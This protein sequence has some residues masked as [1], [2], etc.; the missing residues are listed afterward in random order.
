MTIIM[1]PVKASARIDVDDMLKSAAE[2]FAK[3]ID[4]EIFEGMQKEILLDKGWTQASLDCGY[5]YKDRIAATGAWVHVHATGDYKFLNGHW[6]F[7]RAEDA[8]MFTLKFS[9]E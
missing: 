7:E 2:Q 6:L 8:T 9:C 3:E 1:Q 5:L 4:R